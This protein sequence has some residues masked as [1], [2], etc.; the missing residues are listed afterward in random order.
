MLTLARWAA[1][2]AGRARWP[3]SWAAATTAPVM[4]LATAPA[5][6]D[7]DLDERIARHRAER[8]DWPT[9]EEPLDLAGALDRRG[10]APRRS[11]TA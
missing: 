7:A 8:P 10:D 5:S 3:S 6:V 4:F 11:S 9:I 1:R 2:A